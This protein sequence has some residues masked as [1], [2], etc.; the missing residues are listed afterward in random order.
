MGNSSKPFRFIVTDDTTMRDLYKWMDLRPTLKTV[1]IRKP[2]G[3]P[4]SPTRGY[5]VI[6]EITNDT[7]VMSE[8]Q[9]SMVEALNSAVANVEDLLP[10]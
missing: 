1:R 6:F 4:V 3:D 8:P 10:L 7:P 5:R 9:P 2:N